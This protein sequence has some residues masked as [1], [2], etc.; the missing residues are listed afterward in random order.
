MRFMPPVCV[1]H[2]NL[3]T[4]LSLVFLHLVFAFILDPHRRTISLKQQTPVTVSSSS[5]RGMVGMMM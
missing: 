2:H 1:C 5:M 3:V 4:L